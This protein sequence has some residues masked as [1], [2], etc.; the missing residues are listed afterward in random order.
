MTLWGRAMAW[1]R[2]RFG[3][4]RAAGRPDADDQR[5]VLLDEIERDNLARLEALGVSR[6]TIEES[7][8]ARHVRVRK[9]A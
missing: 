1:L 9:G 8:S 4:D 5:L 3:R 2:R 6:R 7:F